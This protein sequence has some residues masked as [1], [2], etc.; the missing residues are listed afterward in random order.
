MT[1]TELTLK[2]KSDHFATNIQKVLTILRLKAKMLKGKKE[3]G[4]PPLYV[5]TRAIEKSTYS[6]F[7]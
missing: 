7:P 3:I 6:K 5:P 1:V 4:V 2:L